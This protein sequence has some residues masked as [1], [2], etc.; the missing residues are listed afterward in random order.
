M[1]MKTRSNATKSKQ[2]CLREKANF[3]PLSE[4]DG[5]CLDLKEEAV[6]L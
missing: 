2:I 5:Q 1:R 6:K 3:Y 4:M